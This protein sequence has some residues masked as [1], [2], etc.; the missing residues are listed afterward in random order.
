[1]LSCATVTQAGYVDQS[2][3]VRMGDMVQHVDGK[4]HGQ[5][6]VDTFVEAMRPP[7]DDS[8]KWFISVVGSEGCGAC[9]RLKRDWSQSSSLLALANRD[10]PKES[11]AHFNWYYSEDQSQAWRFKNISITEYPTVIVQ[12]PRNGRYGKGST[13]VYQAAGYNGDPQKLAKDI[14]ASVRMYV[15]KLEN[16][17]SVATDFGVNPPWRPA[18]NDEQVVPFPGKTFSAIDPAGSARRG[19]RPDPDPLA[20]DSHA[21]CNGF[22][23]ACD[24]RCSHL[25]DLCHPEEAK[26]GWLGVVIN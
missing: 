2:E 21:F 17:P 12:P 15:S 18:P 10:N 4:A 7:E 26:R 5:S 8:D 13:V 22:F 16:H 9:Q 20:T 25:G 3:I 6:D 19:G 24:Y 23:A 1:L 14:V 11:W